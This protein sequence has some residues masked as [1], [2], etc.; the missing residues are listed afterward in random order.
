MRNP[1]LRETIRS[2]HEQVARLIMD[3]VLSSKEMYESQVEKV[4]EAGGLPESNKTSYEEMKRFV[5][6][7]QY[8]LTLD[9]T[10]EVGQEMRVFDKILPLIFE[11]GWI[12]LRAPKNSGSFITSDHPFCLFWTDPKQRGGFYPPGLGLRGTE[13]R[14]TISP[15]LALVGAFEL[16][17]GEVDVSEESVASVNGG[18]IALAEAQV[19][20]RDQNFHYAMQPDEPLQKASEARHRQALLAAPRGRGVMWAKSTRT[21]KRSSRPRKHAPPVAKEALPAR[22][23]EM[24]RRAGPAQ[25]LLQKITEDRRA[26][27][28]DAMHIRALR[29]SSRERQLWPYLVQEC[30]HGLPVSEQH[31]KTNNQTISHIRSGI[32]ERNNCY[33]FLIPA[34]ASVCKHIT[35]SNQFKAALLCP[36]KFQ[37]RDVLQAFRLST[38]ETPRRSHRERR[39][40]HPSSGR[41]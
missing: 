19:Y 40:C 4:R 35:R 6:G 25:I 31:R 13:I 8:E 26:L 10:F 15:R 18:V 11:R 29:W 39:V 24:A 36:F 12:L 37:S 38:A 22:R 20:A 33:Q 34:A 17:N 30:T 14:F 16:K 23:Y 41:G 27:R 2:G 7:G 3:Q 5:E 28:S 21:G 32:D 9:N 1:R